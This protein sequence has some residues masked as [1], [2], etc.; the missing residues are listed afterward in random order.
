LCF[1]PKL[2]GQAITTEPTIR[3][4]MTRIGTA[5]HCPVTTGIPASG[6]WKKRRSTTSSIDCT[7]Y[8]VRCRSFQGDPRDWLKHK[9]CE[10]SENAYSVR[11]VW[12]LESIR[13]G[14]TRA[15]A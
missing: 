14:P 4:S 8:L 3:S 12:S 1:A 2:D 13:N 7:D 15:A 9:F 10:R 5:L 6:R 11:I